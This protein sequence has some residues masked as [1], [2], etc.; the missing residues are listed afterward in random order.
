[1]NLFAKIFLGFW[2]SM[3]A[4]IFSWLLAGQYFIPFEEIG[5]P[6]QGEQADF[7]QPFAPHGNLNHGPAP[8]LREISAASR[9]IYRIFY[10]LQ[11]VPMKDLEGWIREREREDGVDIRLVDSDGDEI[12]KRD[13]LPGSEQVIARLE[14]FRRRVLQREAGRLLF[15]QEMYRPEWGALKLIISRRP[16]KS[17]LVRFLTDHLWLRL[18][19]ATLISAAISYAIS[20]YLTRPLQNLQSASRELAKGNLSAR[21]DV[22]TRGGD[23]TDALGRDFNTMAEQL[24][25]KI[26]AQARLLSD[27]SHELRS[28]L[29]R[30]RVALALA[31]K[32]PA[33]GSEQLARI[34][35]ETELLDDL[36]GQL[37]HSQGA[38]ET[39]QDSFD[40]VAMLQQICEDAAFEARAQSRELV[41]SSAVDEAILRSQGDLLKR[42]LENVIRNAVRHTAPD[43]SVRVRLEVTDDLFRVTVEDSGPGVPDPELERIFEPFYRV[44]EARQRETG[45]FGLG[46]SI[47]RR[48]IEHHG[49][50]ILAENRRTDEGGGLRISIQLP[51][52]S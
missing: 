17:A 6:P 1:M 20:R 21:I 40:L 42:A 28:P 9:D 5:P 16:P 35:R 37:L 32:D 38:G 12:F 36:I 3:V 34:E 24:Q 22:P 29:A 25:D 18:L 41:F 11:T 43:T 7:T 44:D 4:I 23:E 15:G 50:T 30:M 19:L 2:L 39:M 14:G 33:R 27:V 47:A 52:G 51:A 26:N 49:G 46:L 10:G 48:A 31:E 13:L 8:A 45:G